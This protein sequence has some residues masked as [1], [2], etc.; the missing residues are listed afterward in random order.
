MLQIEQGTYKP[1]LF[2]ADKR[3]GKFIKEEGVVQPA[4]DRLP[5]LSHIR[6]DEEA[7]KRRLRDL[8]RTFIE[9]RRVTRENVQ[10]SFDAFRKSIEKQRQTLQDKFGA[11]FE[12]KVSIEDGKTK[13]KGVA[14]K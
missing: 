4:Q 14:K 8:Y 9:T 2:K 5:H 10:V 6:D 3:V 12:F 11:K 7:E 13:I 1:D